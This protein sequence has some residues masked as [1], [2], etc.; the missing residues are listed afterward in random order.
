M[1]RQ[2][3]SRTGSRQ[4][5]PVGKVKQDDRIILEEVAIAKVIGPLLVPLNDFAVTGLTDGWKS[6][7][8]WRKKSPTVI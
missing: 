1:G 5:I 8:C 7:S 3:V 4:P 2:A 6:Q